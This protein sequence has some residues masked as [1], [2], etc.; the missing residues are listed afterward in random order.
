MVESDAKSSSPIG[1]FS[2]RHLFL[3]HVK[4]ALM[5]D[6]LWDIDDL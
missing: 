6:L 4:R 3:V 5:A 1:A 2:F